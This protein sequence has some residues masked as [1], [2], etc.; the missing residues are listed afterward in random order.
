VYIFFQ[1]SHL[2][3]S[4]KCDNG[5]L[6]RLPHYLCCQ[7]VIWRLAEKL[8]VAAAVSPVSI[9][10]AACMYIPYHHQLVVIY[11]KTCI[12]CKHQI[13]A[14]WTEF[15]ELP[16]TISLSAYNLFIRI[17]RIY[18]FV[19]LLIEC[20]CSFSRCYPQWN[21][22]K[23]RCSFSLFSMKNTKIVHL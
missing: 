18:K 12:F 10:E 6:L 7:D 1:N 14:I 11:C 9:P 22:P 16:I 13:F 4:V 2:L 17:Q 3:W 20:P 15:L 19:W 21:S 5:K 23:K 8:W